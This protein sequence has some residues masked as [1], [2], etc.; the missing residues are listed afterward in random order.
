MI[1][2]KLTPI[3]NLLQTKAAK[4]IFGKYYRE[5]EKSSSLPFHLIKYLIQSMKQDHFV[6]DI[7]DVIFYQTDPQLNK[8]N[9]HE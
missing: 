9:H 8:K 5:P 6:S 2:I 3:F 1:A 4:P 7:G